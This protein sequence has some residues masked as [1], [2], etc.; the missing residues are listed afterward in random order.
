MGMTFYP[1]SHP[2]PRL[3]VA[4]RTTQATHCDHCRWECAGGPPGVVVS[5]AG[6][7]VRKAL[8]FAS[9]S[10]SFYDTGSWNMNMDAKA[11]VEQAQG[12]RT[13][14]GRQPL[15]RTVERETP[16]SR[17][18]ERICGSNLKTSKVLSLRR[19]VCLAGFALGL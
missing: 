18:V 16:L 19:I 7:I 6:R 9:P 13:I 5:K 1:P 12:R 11:S 15:L 17:T 2:Y 14:S 3:P 10:F 8:D 4:S